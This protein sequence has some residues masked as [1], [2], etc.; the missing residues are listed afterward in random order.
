[1]RLAGKIA[2]VTGG[3]SGIGRAIALRFAQ[4]GAKVLV[5]DINEAGARETA[6]QATRAGG[7]ASHLRADVT[8]DRDAADM[9]ASAVER[10]GGL[11]ILVNNA[12]ILVEGA[13]PDLTEEAW[14]RQLAVNLKGPFLCSKYAIQQ[15]RRQ[16]TGGTIINMASVNSY[17]AE[18]GIAAYC[19]SKG[20]L[21]QL[22]KA[23]A[24]DHSAEGIRVNC[25]CPGW[26]E[27]PMNAS[28]FSRPGGR[29]L[30]GKMQA[31]GRVGVPDEVASVALF[32]ASD[33][34]SFVTGA[35]YVVDGGFSAGVSKAIGLV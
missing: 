8:R 9:V 33:E 22:T 12:G 34:A 14:D 4:E 13:V 6:S 25:I 15:F 29:E 24:I 1:M 30:A 27:T 19:A 20:G 35:A 23:M 2:I 16:G 31:I 3:G 18:G 10:Y 32:L 17:F 21:M 11:H 28:Y 5:A 26:T 7:E